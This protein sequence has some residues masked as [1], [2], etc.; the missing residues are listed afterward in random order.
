ML[1]DYTQEKMKNFTKDGAD[2]KT[3]GLKGKKEWDDHLKKEFEKLKDL[4]KGSTDTLFKHYTFVAVTY[5][6]KSHVLSQRHYAKYWNMK[7][8]L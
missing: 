6:R 1:A 4:N 5:G 8:A 2:E 3:V 7:Q